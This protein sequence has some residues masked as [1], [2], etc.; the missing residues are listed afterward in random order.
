M[1]CT[2]CGKE[3]LG[4]AKF[5]DGCGSPVVSEQNTNPAP[6]QA[7]AAPAAAI[8]EGQE[9][10]TI[11][12]LS[13]ILFFLPLVSCPGSKTGRF[14]ANQGLVLL[15]ASVA[16]Q[17]IVTILSSIL[18]SLSWRLWSIA[19]LLG[20]G[21]AIVVLAFVIIGMVNA[22]KGEQKPLPIIGKLTIIK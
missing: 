20:W 19:S 6:A 4:E 21:W 5:C 3:L 12:I 13:Y 1:H 9:N 8:Q 2:N 7:A 16:G 14:H 10:K 11:F 22:S 17:I 18:I 15:I